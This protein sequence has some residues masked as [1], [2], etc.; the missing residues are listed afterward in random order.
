M[1]PWLIFAGMTTLVWGVWGAFMEFPERF[2]FPATL[3]Y[4]A[5][6]ATM[7]P[8]AWLVLP[9]GRAGLPRDQKSVLL[10]ACAG[11]LGAGGQ[12]ILFFALKQGP[13]YLIFPIISL[14]PALTV[15]LA[16][17]LLKERA[18]RRSGVGIAVAILSVLLLSYQEPGGS[19]V[20]GYVW[21]MLAVLIMVMWGLQAFTMKY[22]CNSMSP[23]IIFFY[24]TACSVILVPVALLMTDNLHG[25]NWGWS[26][27]GLSIAVQL[28]N[29]IGALSLV[30]A[31]RHGKA[32]IVTPLTALAPVITV[33]L[34]LLVYQVLPHW[35]V[36]SGLVL[37]MVAIAMLVLENNCKKY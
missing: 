17:T 7:I 27:L 24:M 10:G 30:Y 8:C 6:A 31:M 28:L 18:G 2:G 19:S 16:V 26:G 11:L 34:S 22:A 21:L 25:V 37:A 4:V 9:R 3:G 13:A 12:L 14:Y 20:H 36:L 5:W 29:A 23:E 1:K 15:L 33:I 35:I 32:I